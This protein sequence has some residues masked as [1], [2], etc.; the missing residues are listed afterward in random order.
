[1]TLIRDPLTQ[2]GA[3]VNN[4]GRLLTQSVQDSAEAEAARIGE[5]F[6]LGSSQSLRALT[7][8]AADDGPIMYVRNISATKTLVLD[9]F[10][11]TEAGPGLILYL[12]KNPILGA[13]GA[14]VPITPENRNFSSTNE[15]EVEAE[16]WDDTG[17][18]G[19]TG[20]T[21]GVEV[22]SFLRAVPAGTLDLKNAVRLG[23]L[24]SAYFAYENPTGG[25][26][27]AAVALRFHMEELEVF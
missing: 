25:P 26:I 3:R 12:V 6:T 7:Y 17:A 20:L 9:G 22:A 14:N 2:R 4:D 23:R 24:D 21:G 11:A 16:V 18:L 13:I 19:I 15:A 1:M 8:A 10:T 5:A 27:G